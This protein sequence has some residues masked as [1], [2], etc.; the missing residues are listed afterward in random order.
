MIDHVQITVGETVGVEGRGD[1]Y[2]HSG[3][4]RDMVQNHLMQLLCLLAMEPPTSLEADA[5]RDEK[6]KVLRSLKPIAP[7]RGRPRDGARA[8]FSQGAVD[9]KA[10]PG[11]L[12]DLGPKAA[13]AAPRRSWR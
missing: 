2:D 4:L 10:V 1:Y 8:V 11:Y 12:T 6:L 5:V 7:A 13:P 3:A 9:G